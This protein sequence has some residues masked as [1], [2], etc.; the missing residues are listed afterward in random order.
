[1]ANAPFLAYGRAAETE[2]VA[3]KE[4]Q[5]AGIK[6]RPGITYQVSATG[7]WSLG[8]ICGITD[9]DGN[10]VSPFCNDDHLGLGVQGSS[11]LGRIGRTGTPF[12]VGSNRMLNPGTEG[13]LFLRSYDFLPG[14]NTGS[15]KVR[16]V[17]HDTA[18]VGGE[19][20]PAHRD[21]I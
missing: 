8:P 3:A 10:G 20:V 2:V 18:A 1:M 19:A 16:I 4:W 6:L 7:T 17:Q 13:E 14:D 9:A 5:S 15:M 11:L 21:P 12:L